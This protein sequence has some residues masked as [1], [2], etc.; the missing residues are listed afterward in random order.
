[1]GTIH[2]PDIYWKAR[3][4][5]IVEFIWIFVKQLQILCG[6][7]LL[8][9]GKTLIAFSTSFLLIRSRDIW[10]QQIKVRHFISADFD[11]NVDES[12]DSTNCH[13]ISS[14]NRQHMKLCT[15]KNGSDFENILY[16]MFPVF[17]RPV[18]T[19][20]KFYLQ[21]NRISNWTNMWILQVQLNLCYPARFAVL[22][23]LIS[24]H[25]NVDRRRLKFVILET[26]FRTRCG[27]CK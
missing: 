4:S 24:E 6:L 20:L 1:M 26:N 21:W 2:P 25:L 23:F 19:F 7:L 5:R 14:A 22:I 18:A 3:S 13:I 9:Q 12:K 17:I 15:S 11:E 16:I 8:K 10:G 27:L